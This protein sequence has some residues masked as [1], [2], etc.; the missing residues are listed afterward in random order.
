MLI[1]SPSANLY[2]LFWE[3]NITL[4][5]PTSVKLDVFSQNLMTEVHFVCARLQ[6][7][8][9][10]HKKFNVM[11]ETIYAVL[12]SHQCIKNLQRMMSLWWHDQLL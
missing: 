1:S 9:K 5:V 11:T 3:C 7:C 4:V 2:L 10:T 6:N 8:N 12:I